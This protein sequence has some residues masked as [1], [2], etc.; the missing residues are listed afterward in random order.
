MQ[1]YEFVLWFGFV[2]FCFF[3]LALIS[4]NVMY[5]TIFFSFFF[6]VDLFISFAFESFF[7]PMFIPPFVLMFSIYLFSSSLLVL[8]FF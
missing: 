7:F 1:L 2:F 4:E 5:A 8:I 6:L 3:F